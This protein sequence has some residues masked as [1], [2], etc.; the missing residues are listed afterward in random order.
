MPADLVVIDGGLGPGESVLDKLR[1]RPEDF[2]EE[3]FRRVLQAHESRLPVLEVASIL[4]RRATW[5]ELAHCVVAQMKTP[6]G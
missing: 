6:P 1:C 4:R 3:V 2:P 5:S